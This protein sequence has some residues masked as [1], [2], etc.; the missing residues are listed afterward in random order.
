[1]KLFLTGATGY[2]GSAVARA[3]RAH[4]HE[5]SVLAHHE[6]ARRELADLGYTAVDGDIREPEGFLPALADAD[7]VIHAAN[8]GQEDAAEVDEEVTKAMIR[9]LE[10]SE[11]AFLYTSG[12]WVLGDTGD[13]AAHEDAVPS[14]VE[15]VGWRERL[16]SWVLDAANRDVRS[17]VIRP[18]IVY[19]REGGI[20]G[21]MARGELPLVG[22]GAQRWP[23]VHVDD[24]AEL[25]VAAVERAPA[26]S[27]LHGVAHEATAG[28]VARAMAPNGLERLDLE[29]ARETLGAFAD[30]L[31]LDQ[32]ISSART[33]ELLGWSPARPAPVEAAAVST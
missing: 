14:P 31:A 27:V 28:D 13:D 8:S 9:A 15:L 19:G 30:A 6:R 11:K 29:E 24:L 18:G 22:S 25:Y 5:I 10:G 21:M 26:G 7:G 1:M 32:R 23:M 3:A 2:I 12:V 17:V 4:G 33:R 20:P 16:E